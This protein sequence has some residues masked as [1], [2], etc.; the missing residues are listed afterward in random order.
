MTPSHEPRSPRRVAIVDDHGIFAEALRG[1]VEGNM[2]D[3]L[4]VYSGPDPG[5][6]PD[7]TELVLLD[8][9]LGIGR[10]A[11]DVTRELVEAGMDVLLVSAFGDPGLI[12]PAI[13]AGA[14]GYVPKRVDTTALREAISSALAGEVHVSPDLAAVMMA[15]VDRPSLSIQERTA[16]QLYAS[17]LTLEAVAHRMHVSPSTAREY[18]L[19]V[20]RKY[21]DVGRDVRTKTDLYAAA[22]HDGLLDEDDPQHRP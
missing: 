21:A 10:S 11:A 17:G 1:W 5:Q 16:L 9:E 19:R 12:R 2:D 3:V 20:R 15:A 18:L 6:V 13:T 22:L 4:V 14:L 8:I 7:D